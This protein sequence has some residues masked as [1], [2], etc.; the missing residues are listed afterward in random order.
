MS[1]P[2]TAVAHST[3][4]KTRKDVLKWADFTFKIV[5]TFVAFIGVYQAYLTYRETSQHDL[6]IRQHDLDMKFIDQKLRVFE[7]AVTAAG[8]LMVASPADFERKLDQFGI[9]KH[10]AARMVGDEDVYNAMVRVYNAGVKI[11]NRDEKPSL[12]GREQLEQEFE[13]LADTCNK[14]LNQELTTAGAPT[15]AGFAGH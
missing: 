14:Q 5:A 13:A 8:E 12:E 15:T 10:G 3:K 1:A 7:E 11:Y 6:A 4:P 2:G 9:V